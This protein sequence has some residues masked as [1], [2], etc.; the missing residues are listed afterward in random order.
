MKSRDDWI[1]R[2]HRGAVAGDPSRDK[3]AHF[4]SY[5]FNDV[6]DTDILKFVPA[7]KERMGLQS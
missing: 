3:I 1:E 5:D 2:V 4:Y 7:L 6:E